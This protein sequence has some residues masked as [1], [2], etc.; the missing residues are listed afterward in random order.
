MRC[1]M[2]RE[3]WGGGGLGKLEWGWLELGG[4]K[5]SA[6]ISFRVQNPKLLRISETHLG[7]IIFGIQ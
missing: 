4:A 5:K 7:F 2:K 3:R 6:I 1:E